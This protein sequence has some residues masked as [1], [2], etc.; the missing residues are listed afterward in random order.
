MKLLLDTHVLI[1]A[2][3]ADEQLGE[4]ARQLLLDSSNA[5]LVS[6]VSSLEL[7]RLISLERVKISKSLSDWL[8]EARVHL[9]FA[10]ADFTH[11]IAIRSYE[12]P[13]DFHKDPADRMLV[14]TAIELD[15]H[16]LTA[17][18][19]ILNYAHVKSIDARR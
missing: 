5:L 10:D 12:L 6:P 15:C 7:S 9:G 3:S 16:L 18:E 4:V 8:D 14:A 1:W 2:E 19:Q 11:T 17:D 13:G